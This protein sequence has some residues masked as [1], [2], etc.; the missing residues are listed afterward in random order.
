MEQIAPKELDEAIK[1]IKNEKSPA[2]NRITVKMIKSMGK[3]KKQIY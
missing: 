1:R 3:K 2:L